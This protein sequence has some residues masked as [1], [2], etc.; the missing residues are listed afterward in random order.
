MAL[1]GVSARA[2]Q[3][4]VPGQLCVRLRYISHSDHNDA[5]RLYTPVFLVVLQDVRRVTRV[6]DDRRHKSRSSVSRASPGTFSMTENLTT[7]TIT[8]LPPSHYTQPKWNADKPA[9]GAITS[10]AAPSLSNKPK[11]T[12]AAPRSKPHLQPASPSTPPSQTT[13]PSAPTTNMTRPS[14]GALQ[15]TKS[16]STTNTPTS[17]A[18]STLASLSLH[19]AI[20]VHGWAHSQKRSDYCC[21]RRYD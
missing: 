14:P 6:Q 18:L 15:R 21:L 5:G 17:P 12:P 20:R 13:R 1:E 7:I 4:I 19:P 11:P 10:T 2:S 8:T 9:N 3:R 16:T